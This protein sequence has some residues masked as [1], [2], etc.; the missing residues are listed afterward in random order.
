MSQRGAHGTE[1]R[2][3]WRQGGRHVVPMCLAM[4]P[5]ER[6][7]EAYLGSNGMPDGGVEHSSE[8][9]RTT[10]SKYHRRAE[11]RMGNVVCVFGDEG[12]PAVEKEGRQ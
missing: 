3:G 9:R 2:Q 11:E 12:R 4:L 7:E 10:T 1:A 8:Q 6:G 5:Q